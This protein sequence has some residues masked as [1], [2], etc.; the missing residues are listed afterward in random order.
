MTRNG[1]TLV[2]LVV[3]VGIIG[4]LLTV[5]TLQFHQY[6]L[7]ANIESQ[8]R[9]MYADLMK[10]RSE[11]ALQKAPRSFN[12]TDTDFIVY[13]STDGS[14]TPLHHTVF[15]YPASSEITL[16]IEFDTRGVAR[17]PGSIPSMAVCV[18]P[19]GN[20]AFI[21]SIVITPTMIQMGKW[22]QGSCTSANIDVQ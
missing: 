8:V 7:K 16:S 10:A 21:D 3:V 18:Q 5:G 14:G 22:K 11:A 12:V 1:F 20:P 6:T 2:E 17:F 13:P 15:K 9:T 4:I 19:L